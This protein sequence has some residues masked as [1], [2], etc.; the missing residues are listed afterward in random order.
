MKRFRFSLDTL[1]AIR[2]EKETESKI[3]LAQEIGRLY[4]I[5]QYI[6]NAEKTAWAVFESSGSDIQNLRLRELVRRK[7][8]QDIEKMQK[9]LSEAEEAVMEAR[10]I[11]AE[12]HV[13][14]NVLLR[15]KE[16][17]YRQWKQNIKKEEIKVLDETANSSLLRKRIRGEISEKL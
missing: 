5:R 4:E 1:L 14:A 7:A 6:N 3:R 11:Y 10:K 12:D 8:A 13:K 2:T 16:K 17:K 9:P 15:L